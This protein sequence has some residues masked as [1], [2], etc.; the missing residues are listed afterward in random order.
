MY[1]VANRNLLVRVSLEE[2]AGFAERPY[3]PEASALVAPALQADASGHRALYATGRAFGWGTVRRAWV[4][5]QGEP[6]PEELAPWSSLLQES[7]RRYKAPVYL[8]AQFTRRATPLL[9]PLRRT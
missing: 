8:I 3:L 4:V 6:L 5:R 9:L 7:F 1:A 2:L